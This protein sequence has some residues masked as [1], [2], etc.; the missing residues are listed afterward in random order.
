MTRLLLLLAAALAGA[1][2]ALRAAALLA[3]LA[4]LRIERRARP[5]QE[6]RDID[7]DVVQQFLDDLEAEMLATEDARG[8]ID[9]PAVRRS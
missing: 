8:S 4:R 7:L 2:H 9:V 5:G 6:E 1:E 3:K